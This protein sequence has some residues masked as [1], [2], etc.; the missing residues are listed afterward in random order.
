MQS[1][2]YNYAKIRCIN[3]AIYKQ[4]ITEGSTKDG[5]YHNLNL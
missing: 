3:V 4:H 1:D 2:L 5:A